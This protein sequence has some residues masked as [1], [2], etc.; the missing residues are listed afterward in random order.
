[1]QTQ[2]LNNAFLN[3]Q[4]ISDEVKKL[5]VPRIKWKCQYNR[6]EPMGHK[7]GVVK[8]NVIAVDAYIRKTEQAQILAQ[9]PK[10]T[11]SAQ[12]QG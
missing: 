10:K 4:W 1:M 2:K 5:N 12:I 11:M 9:G 6:S 3:N 7:K 8:G